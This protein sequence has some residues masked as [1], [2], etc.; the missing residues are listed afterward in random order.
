MLQITIDYSGSRTEGFLQSLFTTPEGVPMMILAEEDGNNAQQYP[1]NEVKDISSCPVGV[2]IF[3][4]NQEIEALER[5]NRELQIQI[6]TLMQPAVQEAMRRPPTPV[7]IDMTEALEQVLINGLA[8]ENEVLKRC[9]WHYAF[10][11]P[12]HSFDGRDL[13]PQERLL[14]KVADIIKTGQQ[15]IGLGNLYTYVDQ[16]E[17]I[18]F[19]V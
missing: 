1:I 18:N 5:K 8:R 19:P 11:K 10:T 16:P 9:V 17:F 13:T 3:D 6:D 2:A 12:K 15:E 7:K 4:S 14:E